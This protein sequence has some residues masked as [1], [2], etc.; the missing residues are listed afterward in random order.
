MVGRHNQ[1]GSGSVGANVWI[2][3][4]NRILVVDISRIVVR[5]FAVSSSFHS[6]W[7][8]GCMSYLFFTMV[9]FGEL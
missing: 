8:F 1:L 3:F 9:V 6:L 4:C 7:E 2:E 5:V